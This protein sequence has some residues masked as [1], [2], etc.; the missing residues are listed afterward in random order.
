[1]SRQFFQVAIIPGRL[2]AMVGAR[3]VLSVEPADAKTI[4]VGGHRAELG[5]QALVNQ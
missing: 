5:M 2:D 3:C 4:T 1:V